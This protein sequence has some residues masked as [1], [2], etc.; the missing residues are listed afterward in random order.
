V[1]ICEI[2]KEDFIV[3]SRIYNSKNKD[4]ATLFWFF[5]LPFIVGVISF[6]GKYYYGIQE[7]SLL[8]SN[9][10]SSLSIFAG[11]LFSFQVFS[12]EI[13]R[14]IDIEPINLHTNNKKI[15]IREVYI[16]NSTS[17]IL[18]LAIILFSLVSIIIE[19]PALSS[20]LFSVVVFLTICLLFHLLMIIKRMYKL[21]NLPIGEVEQN[22]EQREDVS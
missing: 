22:Q 14:R 17:I 5:G 2:I 4:R 1:C 11:G 19:V 21:F 9:L 12:F 20:V 3:I 7:C 8:I 6:I 15:F 16:L 18:I 13:K 10:V